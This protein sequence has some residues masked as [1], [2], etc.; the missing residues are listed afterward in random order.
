MD[1][2]DR[3]AAL[4]DLEMA[5]E[6]AMHG[7]GRVAL[8]KGEAGIGKTALVECFARR[9]HSGVRVLWGGCDALFS[10]RPLGPLHDIAAQIGGPFAEVV[11]ASA[12]RS[13]VFG[14]MLAELHRPAIVVVEDAHWADEA[15]LDVL[16]YVSRRIGRTSA[17]LVLTY[18]DDELGLGHALRTYLGD[19]ASSTSTI[20][21]DLPP[22]S[23]SAVAILVGQRAIDTA[24]LHRQTGGNPFFVTEILSSTGSGLPLSIRDAVLGRVARLSSAAV[25]LVEAA[26]IIGPRIECWLLEA[27]FPTEFGSVEECLAGGVLVEHGDVLAFRHELARQAVLDSIPTLRQARLHRLILAALERLPDGR[28][29]VTRLAHHAEGARDDRAILR[30]VPAAA[31]KAAAAGAHRAA[32]DLLTRGVQSA[33]T[34]PSADVAAL[35]EAHAMEC[36]HV[37][38]LPSAIASWRQAI[39]L[40]RDTGD[41]LRQ[42]MNLAV[43]AAALASDGQ[44]H[45][46]RRANQEAIDLLVTLPPGRELALAYGTQAILHQYNQELADAIVLSERAIALA[47]QAGATQILVMA[48]D[49]LGMSSMFLDYERGCQYLE[50]ARDLAQAAGLDA[51]VARAYGDLGAVSVAV[52]HLDEAERYL[53]DGLSFTADRDLDRTRLYMLAWLSAAH[54]VRGRWQDAR[55]SAAEVL[56]RPASSSARVIALLTLGRL[57]AR[58][59]DNAVASPLLDQALLMAGAPEELRLMGP[60]RAA[61]AEALALIGD[62]AGTCAEVERVYDIALQKRHRWV[63]GELAYW[64]WRVG[65]G[66][67]PP[68]WIARPFALQVAGEWQAAAVAW[69]QLGCPYEEA[70]ALAEG[71]QVAR[72][73]AL[74][75]FDRLG[76]R[77]AAAELRRVMRVQGVRRVPRGPRPATRANRFGLTSRQFEILLLLAEGFTNTEIAQRMSISPKTAEHHV[78]AVLAKLDVVSRQAAVAVARDHQLIA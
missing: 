4:G 69:Q 22:L 13:V 71:D 34:L 51:E 9:H 30:F 62:A 75:T 33:A 23:E 42:G 60:V 19:V 16:R 11:A 20:R 54:L 77:A 61:R 48:Y 36:F 35:L 28:V 59:G 46:A 10:P 2:L 58:R 24:A 49:T 38:D 32:A 78:A 8:V 17:L 73:Q 53:R 15:T 74:A 55:S 21:V 44:R 47:E 37:A 41:R 6:H 64:R 40:W 56:A 67:S 76:A 39:E 18:R 45:E 68:D 72:E 52:F 66:E 43:L 3:D 70:R 25:A 63:A 50:H 7:E 29:D 5:L 26:A 12:R 1:L 27:V 65:A 57:E 14:A 31:R